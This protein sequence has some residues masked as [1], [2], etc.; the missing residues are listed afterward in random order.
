M[1]LHALAGNAAAFSLAVLVASCAMAAADA[2]TYRLTSTVSLGSPDSWDYLTYDENSHHVFVSHFDRVTV[3]DVASGT[4]IGQITGFPGGT[5]GI[6]LSTAQ[7]RGYTDDSEAGIAASFDL[8]TFKV[9]KRLAAKDDADGIAFDPVSSHVF[10]IDGDSGFVTVIDPL[11]D[12]VLANISVGSKLEFAVA[13]NDGKLYVNDAGKSEIVR[14]DTQTNQVDARWPMVGCERPHGLAIDSQSHRLFSTCPNQV[15]K[16]VNTDSGAVVAT[17]P[18]G[19]GTDAA[20]FDPKR[21]R[22][23]SSNGQ[24]GTLTVVQELDPNTFAVID[25]VTTAVSGRTMAIDPQSGRIF[26][27]AAQIDGSTPT[28]AS[29][30]VAAGPASAPAQPARRRLPIVPGSLK[31]L[32]L[33]PVS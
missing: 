3:V 8:S 17:L 6:A 30:P 18:I 13:G 31:L 5:H 20:A 7:R 9:Q 2:P 15:M 28:P 12:S 23:F 32:I 27:A 14:I 11:T 21:K 26:I 19:K 10:V 1:T 33:D 16:V 25:T 29:A 4:V 22:A 24:D